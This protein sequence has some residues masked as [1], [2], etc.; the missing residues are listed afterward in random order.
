[1][2]RNCGWLTAAT[3]KE[4]RARIANRLFAPSILIDKDRWDIDAIY[5]PEIT[6]DI[7]AEAIRLK[8]RMDEKDSVNI[9]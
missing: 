7:Q 3:A 9:F 8:K 1:M 5:I 6:I 2:G 4:Y